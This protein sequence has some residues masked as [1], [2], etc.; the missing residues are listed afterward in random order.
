MSLIIAGFGVKFL[1][2][3]TKETEVVLKKSD[4]VLYLS[5]DNLSPK[6]IQ[7]INK[8]TE[9]LESIYFSESQ[10]SDAY[11]AIKEKILIEL[12][13]YKNV[14]FIIYGHPNFLVQITSTVADAAKKN[15]YPVY[16]LPGISSLDCLMADL[17]INPGDGGMQI[18]EATELL[19]YK[20]FIDISAHVVIL[21]AAAI[22]QQGHG[23]NK[24]IMALGLELLSIYLCNFYD[25]SHKIVFYEASQ[26]PRSLQKTISTPLSHIENIELSPKTTIYIPPM[27]IKSVDSDM[28]KK[29]KLISDFNTSAKK[30]SI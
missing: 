6:W 27:K 4:K 15:G 26:S 8:N 21:Q 19:I 18:L 14:T 7:D 30:F 3:L 2:H 24:K 22:G 25:S 20:K 1:S 16:V 23:R 12:L 5:N 28:A 17:C 13:T 11:N 10:R 9:S 29:I